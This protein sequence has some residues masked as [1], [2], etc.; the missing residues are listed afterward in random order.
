M[1]KTCIQRG[2]SLFLLSFLLFACESKMDEHY[3]I[4]DWLKGSAWE[5][6]EDR[7]NYA[8][9]LKG[10]ELA[11]FKPIVEGK[12]ILTVMAPDDAAFQAYLTAKG[13]SSID[14]LPKEELSKLIG[15]HLMYYSYSKSMLENFRPDGEENSTYAA[16][17]YYKHRT[18]SQDPIEQV[19]VYEE[20]VDT[21]GVPTYT[22]RE[23]TLYH[24]ERFL[25]VFSHH[26]FKSKRIDAAS[27]YEYFYPGSRWDGDEGFNVS[28]AR[29]TGYGIVTDNGYIYTID[30]VLEPLETIYKELTKRADAYSR[31]LDMYG[32]FARFAKDDELTTNYGNGTDLYLY[33][34]GDQLPPIAYEWSTSNFRS[35]STLSSVAY[36]VFAPSNAAFEAFFESYWRPGGY[37]S[38]DEVDDIAMSYMLGNHVYSG[39]VVFPE[40]ITRGDIVTLYNTK[41]NIDVTKV[42]DRKMCVNGVFYGLEEMAVPEIYR[43]VP[44]A[45][46]REKRFSWYLY[47]LKHSSLLESLTSLDVSMVA[48]MPTNDQLATLGIVKDVNGDLMI[49]EDGIPVPLSSAMMQDIVNMHLVT[50]GTALS[51]SGLKVI[52][53]NSPF[54]YWYLKEGK[55]TTSAT[56]TAGKVNNASYDPFVS[57]SEVLFDG[58]RWSNGHVY[59]YPGEVF[60]P[61]GSQRLAALLSIDR[62]ATRPFYQFASLIQGSNL[63]SDGT[64]NFIGPRFIVFIPTNEAITAAIAAGRIPG[65]STDGTVTDRAALSEYLRYYFLPTDVNGIVDYPYIGGDCA[66]TFSTSRV[67]E[68]TP[69]GPVYARLSILDDG[70]KLSVRTSENVEVKVDERFDYFPFAYQDG[71]FHLIEDILEY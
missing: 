18:K 2:W 46:F 54:N 6:L 7:G 65:V 62:D 60:M 5:V 19:T 59:A 68:T 47:L 16:G 4:P 33:G 21:D 32:Q 48:L 44:G 8:I 34:H 37:T 36:S 14:Q 35:I 51:A 38:F 42:Q 67:A 3:K 50:G 64:L 61:A 1:K 56:F 29:V 10:V 25:P 40:E 24:P 55:I 70:N 28:N 11:G 17:L 31:F 12:S 41:I 45:A 30:K 71:G 63:V 15:F 58:T 66:G 22:P 26:L 57:F 43:A 69:T 20:G 27:N 23:I 49:E 53:T 39:L 52:R 13:V 9:F